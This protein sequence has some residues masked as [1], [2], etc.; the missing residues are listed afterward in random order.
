ML[1]DFAG[2]LGEY[3]PEDQQVEIW[4]NGPSFDCAILDNA[5]QAC[6]IKITWRYSNERC[7]RTIEDLGRKLLNINPKDT[8]ERVG[9]NH[10]ALADAEHQAKY[11]SGV[12]QALQAVIGSLQ[13]LA[14]ER[15]A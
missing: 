9:T 13:H 8:I 1:L 10:H 2:F 11:V 4:G 14:E 6:N 15:V 5:F 12:Y 7:V 3:T